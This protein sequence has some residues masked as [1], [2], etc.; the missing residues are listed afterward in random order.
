MRPFGVDW[1]RAPAQAIVRISDL[2]IGEQPEGT[3]MNALAVFAPR[4][5]GGFVARP[6]SS[7]S[8]SQSATVP[9]TTMRRV[10]WAAG[11]LVLLWASSDH[12]G[13]ARDRSGDVQRVKMI[14]F[15]VADVGREAEFFTSV[16]PL[17]KSTDFP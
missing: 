3:F 1:S 11:V 8:A 6:G 9:I 15:T 2:V 10:L 13:H 16:L 7:S 12:A 4:R 17:E 5:L 14:G